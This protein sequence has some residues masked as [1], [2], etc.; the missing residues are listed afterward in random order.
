MKMTLQVRNLDRLQAALRAS[1]QTVAREIQAFLARSGAK[2]SQTIQRN[3]W[4]VGGVG[5]G[6]PV[7]TGRLRSSHV[8]KISRLS[9]IITPQTDYAKYVHDGT[10]KMKKRP[11]LAYALDTNEKTLRQMLAD[12]GERIIKTIAV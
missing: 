1:P 11:W 8:K 2:L 10:S 3:P 12:T 4:K 5:G 7:D 9:L 6:A